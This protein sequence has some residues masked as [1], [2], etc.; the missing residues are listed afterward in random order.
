MKEL[1]EG[2]LFLLKLCVNDLIGCKI[3]Q[4][5]DMSDGSSEWWSASIVGMSQESERE[6]PMFVIVYDRCEEGDEQ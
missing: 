1:N 3:Q 6:N 4:R 2:R 5:F